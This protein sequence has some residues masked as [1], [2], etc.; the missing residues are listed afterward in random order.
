MALYGGWRESMAEKLT[1][2]FEGALADEHKM[3]F[4]ESARFQYAAARLMVKLAQFRRK[5]KFVSKISAKS[6]LGIQLISQADG[7]FNINI[8]DADQPDDMDYVKVPLSDLIAYVSE[9]I[10]EKLDADVIGEAL[11]EAGILGA[12]SDF[13]GRVEDIDEAINQYLVG[14]DLLAPLSP[15]I[16]DLIKRRVAEAQREKVMIENQETIAKIDSE[17]GQKL[18]AMA[19]PLLSEMAM[20]AL[21]RSAETFEISSSSAEGSRAVLFLDRNMAQDIETAVVDERITPILGDVIQFNKDNGWGK[22]KIEEGAKTLSFSIPYDK[23]ASMKQNLI[24]QMKKDLVY[25]Q[26]YFVRDQANEVKRLIVVGILPTP[27]I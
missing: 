11:A 9:R 10:V 19:A 2:H 14:S 6:N 15:E 7:S 5:G 12:S 17:S 27:T 3:N 21:R 16:K 20:T 13:D 22:V 18:I 25:L 26:T 1:F 8:E 24:D 23:L 4:Y